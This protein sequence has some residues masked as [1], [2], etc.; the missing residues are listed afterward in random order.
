VFRLLP[1]L[2]IEV[3]NNTMRCHTSGALTSLIIIIIIMSRRQG[4]HIVES[5][6]TN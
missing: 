2:G 5:T 1:A 4:D 3:L 6:S